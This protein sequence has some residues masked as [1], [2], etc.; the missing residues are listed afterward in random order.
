VQEKREQI[1]TIKKELAQSEE[2]A[3]IVGGETTGLNSAR[4]ELLKTNRADRALL[5]SIL[6]E[7]DSTRKQLAE[8]RNALE[9]LRERKLEADR[10]AR[11]VSLREQNF[12]L[13]DKNLE[14]SRILAALDKA[15]LSNVALIEKAHV[16]AYSDLRQRVGIVVLASIVGLVFGLTIAFGLEFLNN[17]LRTPEDVEYY[18]KAPVLATI[19]DLRGTPKAIEG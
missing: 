12:R 7:R 17:S 4:Q 1:A 6:S 13:Y 15:Q 9:N 11:N 8:A 16:T 18:L 5:T 2:E 14:E 19:P 3:E 10:L